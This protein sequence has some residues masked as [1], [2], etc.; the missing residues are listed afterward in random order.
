MAHPSSVPVELV[1]LWCLSCFIKLLSH[2]VVGSAPSYLS[3]HIP[4]M[5]NLHY[6]QVQLYFVFLIFLSG[7]C[8]VFLFAVIYHK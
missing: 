5:F 2:L 4:S 7:G 6:K 8:G 3:S 1:N